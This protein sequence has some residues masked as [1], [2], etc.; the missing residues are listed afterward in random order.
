MSSFISLRVQIVISNALSTLFSTWDVCCNDIHNCRM[1]AAW[2][3]HL[4]CSLREDCSSLLLRPLSSPFFQTK[5]HFSVPLCLRE[6][7]NAWIID[8]RLSHAFALASY[9]YSC[10]LSLLF[11]PN[12]ISPWIRPSMQAYRHLTVYRVEIHCRHG[13]SLGDFGHGRWTRG[14]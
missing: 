4:A 12:A 14:F 3:W 10:L 5:Y 7:G 11:S 8:S 6:T 13:L 1:I 2:I 9:G